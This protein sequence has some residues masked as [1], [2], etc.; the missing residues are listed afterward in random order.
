MDFQ[1]DDG[2]FDGEKGHGA[3]VGTFLVCSWVEDV[4]AF[5]NP[6]VHPTPRT[7]WLQIVLLGTRN[8]M[9]LFA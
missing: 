4:L 7:L 1:T 9:R 2:E 8:F 5:I 6:R 3:V